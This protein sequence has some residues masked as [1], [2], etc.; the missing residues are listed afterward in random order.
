ML[1]DNVET[2]KGFHCLQKYAFSWLWFHCMFDGDWLV[3]IAAW[4]FVQP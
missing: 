4:L 2:V 1:S 3:F